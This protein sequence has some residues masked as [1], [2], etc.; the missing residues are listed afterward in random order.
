MLNQA[1]SSVL[2][3]LPFEHPTLLAPMEGVTNAVIRTLL[4]SYGGIGAVCTEF[5]RI[6]GR[7]GLITRVALDHFGLTRPRP[8][9]H[10]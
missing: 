9:A 4:A 2:Q 6:G 7:V 10:F 3:G 8:A 1:S 5:V